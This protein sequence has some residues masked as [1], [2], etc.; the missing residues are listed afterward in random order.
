MHPGL[1]VGLLGGSFDPPH[2][3]HLRISLEAKKRFGLDRVVWLVSPGN[4]LKHNAPARLEE[5]LKAAKHL[6]FNHPRLMTSDYEAR[7]GVRRTY[8]TLRLLKRD[9]P[10]VRF[11]W[12]MGADNLA[13]FHNWGKWHEIM[14]MIPVGVVARPGERQAALNS[15]AAKR[16]RRYRLSASNSHLLGASSAPQWCF[17]NISMSS[18]SSTAI[19]SAGKW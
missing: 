3:G 19:R 5:R 1:R 11:T 17:I 18:Q 7:A 6:T 8:D 13:G 15:V 4:P 9:F 14:Q 2:L 12:L 10:R 16:F